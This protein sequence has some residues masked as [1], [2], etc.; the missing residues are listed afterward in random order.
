MSSSFIRADLSP[1][2]GWFVQEPGLLPNL[3]KKKKKRK[4]QKGI[5]LHKRLSACH[6]KAVQVKLFL[7]SIQDDLTDGQARPS[8]G[9]C[10]WTWTSRRWVSELDLEHRQQLHEQLKMNAASHADAERI[11]LHLIPKI[12][13]GDMYGVALVLDQG[14]VW[15]GPSTSAHLGPC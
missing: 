4:T 5:R 1:F 3:C 9:T 14:R 13:H 15:V 2:L 12:V 11:T 7:T 6:A 10:A 8:T